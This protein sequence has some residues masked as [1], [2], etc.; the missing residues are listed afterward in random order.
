L[1]ILEGQPILIE[2][3]LLVFFSIEF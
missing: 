3:I 2:L 1:H